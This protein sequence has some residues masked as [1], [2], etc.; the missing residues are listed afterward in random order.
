MAPRYARRSS[1]R[2]ARRPL[3][4]PSS[5]YGKLYLPRGTEF[6]LNRY[7]ATAA[8]ASG[9]QLLQRR[10]DGWTGQGRYSSR[11]SIAAGFGR[12]AKGA[13]AAAPAAIAA[14]QQMQ[15]QGLYTGQG[16]Y[17]EDTSMNALIDGGRPPPSSVAQNDETDTITFSDCEFVRDIFAPTI[18][19]G[20]STFEPE[21]IEVNPGLG[22][23]LPNLSQMAVN[24][25]EYEIL[26]CVYEL[27][28][29]ISENNVNNGQSGIA[30]MVFNYNPNEDP[31]DNKEDIM[32]AH[33]SV[34]GRI[35]ERI[36]CGVECDPSKTNKTKF[37][38]R[39]GPVPV[40][41]DNDEYDF[42]A[43]TIATNNIPATFSNTQIFELWCS[44]TVKLRKRKAG[45]LRLLNQQRDLFALV[46]DFT[47]ATYIGNNTQIGGSTGWLKGQQNNIGV[48]LTQNPGDAGLTFI[49]PAQ[50]S[51]IFDVSLVFE[52]GGGIQLPTIAIVAPTV[53]GNCTLLY[54][55][56]TGMSPSSDSP[57]AWLY[58]GST[59]AL[60]NFAVFKV[61][62]KVRSATGG[63]NNVLALGFVASATGTIGAVSVD[64]TE[65]SPLQ[66]TSRVNPKAVMLNIKDNVVVT[67]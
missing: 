66:F 48:K 57:A 10:A 22:S 14:F 29:V 36:V 60:T 6:G 54:D 65:F 61:R 7:G 33:G 47:S 26:Q 9:D 16:E 4:F 32:Q 49:F 45:A 37:F 24:Y 62:V 18:P 56:V 11:R 50:L 3:R 34:S 1:R 30:M 38:I 28:P 5:T 53:L 2:V 15:G 8:L 39:N 35:T 67:Y 43:L 12:F 59:T 58:T 31:Y 40:G 41:K 46:G 42:G 19:S 44:Y 13:L 64:I 51:G 25:T 63:S 21:T 27:R 52:S 55:M 20:S 23:A 17:S